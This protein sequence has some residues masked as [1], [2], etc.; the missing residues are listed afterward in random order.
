MSRRMFQKLNHLLQVFGGRCI[1]VEQGEPRYVVLPVEE[2]IALKNGDSGGN[3]ETPREK[4]AEAETLEKINREIEL[5]ASADAPA[6]APEIS[7]PAPG[8]A[9]EKAKAEYRIEDIPF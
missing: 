8:N 9:G 7:E 2:Y 5:L 3:P 4:G 6:A 1:I